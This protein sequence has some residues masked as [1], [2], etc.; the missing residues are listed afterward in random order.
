M[1][2][3][4]RTPPELVYIV[5][6]LFLFSLHGMTM[7]SEEIMD[8]E[9]PHDEN[10]GDLG[11][12]KAPK[13]E[14]TSLHFVTVT[15]KTLKERRSERDTIEARNVRSH[16][17][18]EYLRRL[19]T[20]PPRETTPAV[21]ILSNHIGRFRISPRP[22]RKGANRSTPGDV[23]PR[24][25]RSLPGKPV[26]RVLIPKDPRLV[27]P[28]D[29]IALRLPIDAATPGTMTLLEYYHTSFWANSLAVNP[30][31]K[32]MSVALSDPPMLH[33]TLCLVALHK[34]QTHGVP[35][36]N[37]YFFHR[38][39]AMRMIT[40]RL[41]DPATATG[42]NTIGAIAI[43][44]TSDNTVSWPEDIQSSHLNGL[45]TLVKL[46]GGIDGLSTNKHIK[47]AVAWADVLHA[48]AHN[49][50]PQL[51]TAKCTTN[52]DVKPLLNLVKRHGY[53][54]LSLDAAADDIVPTALRD[55][56]QNLRLLAKAKALL[57]HAKSN[58]AISEL[59][60]IFSSVL[61][62]TERRVLELGQGALLTDVYVNEGYEDGLETLFCAEATK[63]ACLIFTF[64][65]LRDL[66]LS[67]VFFGRLVGR[68][69][70][71]LE[72]VLDHYLEVAGSR[73]VVEGETEGMALLRESGLPVN[74]LSFLLWL[75]VN[76]YKASGLDE[77]K[78]RREWF[79]QT[80][81]AVC[82]M[83]DI[84]SSL[85]LGTRMKRVC[86]LPDYCL[87]AVEGLWKDIEAKRW[88]EDIWLAPETSPL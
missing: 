19:N 21:S 43:L 69:R 11:L 54:T 63:A 16:V 7:V 23:R 47:R 76:G 59:K 72:S 56:F 64:H 5:L 60:P 49:T 27:L 24:R 80:A 82:R 17:M 85:A 79:V 9:N 41:S 1:H 83:A 25:L 78:E 84:T 66:A 61:F 75:L 45:L 34:L 39:E 77:L 46:R 73:D 28:E 67:A 36:S 22:A 38:G 30:E 37:S 53:S 70:D 29:S 20:V 68:L 48:T 81:D 3:E 50:Q 55:I 8:V 42:D 62:K 74:H 32:W 35:L 87:P 26:S 31:G 14:T 33:A 4:A 52:R 2:H 88:S 51:G 58:E 65:G 18:K 6:A 12:E 86:F 57:L 10:L 40:T 44:S 71:A 13:I 15:A